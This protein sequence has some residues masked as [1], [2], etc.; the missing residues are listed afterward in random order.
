MADVTANHTGVSEVTN[1][2]NPEIIRAA[3]YWDVEVP[4]IWMDV[5][6]SVEDLRGRASATSVHPIRTRAGVATALADGEA[7][8]YTAAATTQTTA[9]AARYGHALWVDERADRLSLQDEILNGLTQA[10]DS[11]RLKMDTDVVGIGA[12]ASNDNGGTNATVFDYAEFDAAITT[13]QSQAKEAQVAHMVIHTAQQEDLRQSMLASQSALF[14][15]IFGSAQSAMIGNVGQGAVG[16]MGSTLIYVSDRVP[17]ADTSGK[18]GFICDDKALT[19]VD[20]LGYDPSVDK[21]YIRGRGYV[22]SCTVDYAVR[23]NDQDRIL[24]VISRTP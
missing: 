23:I 21:D 12:S 15:S 13:F 9:T 7:Y 3:V 22:C 4:Y 2:V 8:T 1:L 14:G 24:E 10:V 17:A 16:R 6:G 5:I 19:L 11:C 20:T 18:G